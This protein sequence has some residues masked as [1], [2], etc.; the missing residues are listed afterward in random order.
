LHLTVQDVGFAGE[1]G[2]DDLGRIVAAV[3]R[4]CADLAPVRLALGPAALVDEGVWLE[5]A[6]AAVRPVRAAV[7]SGIAEV[8]GAARVPGPV[9]DFTPPVS[10]PTA[11]PMGHASR[12]LRPW[13]EWAPRSVTMEVGAIQLIVLHRDSHLYCW[14]ARV[15][16]PLGLPSWFS[17]RI[18]PGC[19]DCHG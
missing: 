2:E 11:T 14:E 1:V 9:G 6:P 18:G 19:F 12:T 17:T 4:R 3:R 8:W 15:I 7:R 10:M 16:A 5:V 13:P